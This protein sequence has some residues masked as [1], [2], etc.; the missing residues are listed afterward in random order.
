MEF[1]TATDGTEV[2]MLNRRQRNKMAEVKKGLQVTE[3]MV[4]EGYTPSNG[5]TKRW[6]NV[7]YMID[8]FVVGGFYGCILAG[9]R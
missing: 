4:Q 7:I 9:Y 1:I 8:P 6:R 3:V 2:R 5:L